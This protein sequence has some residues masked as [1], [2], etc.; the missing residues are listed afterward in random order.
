VTQVIL[1][2]ASV[3]TAVGIGAGTLAM[4]PVILQFTLIFSPIGMG[5]VCC[6]NLTIFRI[7]LFSKIMLGLD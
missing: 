5:G 1:P 3:Y 7:V 6:H 2:F 4:T